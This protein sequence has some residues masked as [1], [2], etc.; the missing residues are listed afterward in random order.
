MTTFS[1]EVDPGI[2]GFACTVRSTSENKKTAQIKISG[3]GCTMIQELAGTVK[4]VSMQDI[5]VPLTKNLIFINAEKAKCHLA[6]P[7]PVAVVKAAEA[8]LVLAL[9]KDVTMKFE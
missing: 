4:E 5:F 9:P 8:A 2:C 3:S 7:V 6:C 1:L